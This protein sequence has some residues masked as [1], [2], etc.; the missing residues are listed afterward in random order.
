MRTPVSKRTIVYP[1]PNKQPLV[2][3]QIQHTNT[4]V[5]ATTKNN[6]QFPLPPSTTPKSDTKPLMQPFSQTS[7]LVVSETAP[8][9]CMSIPHSTLCTLALI[10]THYKPNANI[11]NALFGHAL[12]FL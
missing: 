2:Q 4:P 10:M 3:H 5:L 8:A 9:S 6:A 7:S 11:C 1:T 12:A